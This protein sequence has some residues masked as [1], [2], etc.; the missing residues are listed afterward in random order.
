[1]AR[2]PVALSVV[3]DANVFI[4]A[5]L[6]QAAGPTLDAQLAEWHRSSTELHAPWLLQYEAANALAREVAVGNLSTIRASGAWQRF[7]RLTQDV[8]FHDITDGERVV[9][10]AQQLK[11]QNSY[12]ASYIVL[13]ERLRTDVWT[14]D[15]PLAR[16]AA[17]TGLP[18]KLIE[19]PRAG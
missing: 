5:V 3:V 18:V 11:R 2:E 12:D 13:A 16:N 17:Q 8:V 6:D 15:G 4:A 9:V 14:I 7:E 19:V 10:L 1:M